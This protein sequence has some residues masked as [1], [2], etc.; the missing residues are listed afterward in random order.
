MANC[1]PMSVGSLIGTHNG[2]IDTP[3][4]RGLSGGTDTERL[5][6]LI[7]MVGG[8]GLAAQVVLSR[9]AGRA[10]LA[11][12][13]VTRPR[14]V[15]LARGALSPLVVATDRY[16]GLWWAS[17]PA[18]FAQAGIPV[19]EQHH[20][21]EGTWIELAVGPDRV[22]TVSTSDF[23]P[24]ARAHDQLALHHTYTG[25]DRKDRAIDQARHRHQIR[26]V[27]RANLQ[28]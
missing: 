23:I 8:D 2:D 21:D 22:S 5:Y 10:A 19:I 13:D 7:N 27:R 11:W 12:V 14:R 3:P 26:G 25:W 24:L 16:G 1:S 15:F 20:L 18:W 9:L 28:Q 17:N 6:H 4:V